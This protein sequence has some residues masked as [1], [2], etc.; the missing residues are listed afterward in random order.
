MSGRRL[1]VF[2]DGTWNTPDNGE[3]PTNVVNLLRA[4]P[5]VADGVSQVSFYDKG[6]GTGGLLDKAFGGAFAV[7]L[8]ENMIDGYRFLANNYADG[9]EIYIFG[10]SR[11][12][13]TARSLAGFVCLAGLF[14][15]LHLGGDLKAAV[16]IYKND[17]Y[18]AGRK[19]SEIEALGASRFE[20]V[21][22]DCVGVWDTVGSLGI[23]GD[24]GRRFS[25]KHY[26]HDVQLSD[27]IKVA[28]HAV[29]ID[30]KRSFF[31]PTLWVADPTDSLPE[32]RVVEQVWFPGVHSN[33][34]GSYNDARL[35]DTALD[36]MIK[37]VTMHTN[38]VVCPD[39]VAA[40]VAPDAQGDG[41]ESRTIPLYGGS[42]FYP[43]QRLIGQ[44]V[45]EGSGP[46]D[47]FRERFPKYDRRN[48]PPH[49]LK[50]INEAIHVSALERWGQ[51]VVHDGKPNTSYEPEN[52]AAAIRH[53]RQGGDMPVVGWDGE[54]IAADRVPWPELA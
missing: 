19:R 5:S 53:A 26:Y 36:W 35:S 38:L 2:F 52:L 32:D 7:G 33:V 43:Y 40:A 37:R 30:E 50:P 54:R 34:G 31:P 49:G 17:S 13:F 3:K 29:G 12:A 21:K 51:P 39:Y 10:F 16:D 41:M 20:D 45:P 47:R 15:P 23:P 9:D 44:C 6:V 42:R 11:G 28:L 25:R 1:V 27:G 18:D 24:L 14:S 46:G 22:I 8:T 4:V 48:I